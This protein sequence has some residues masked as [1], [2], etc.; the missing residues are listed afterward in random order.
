MQTTP[1]VIYRFNPWPLV[2][3]FVGML[4]L[5]AVYWQLSGPPGL[6]STAFAIYLGGAVTFMALFVAF[7]W[8]FFVVKLLPDGIRSTDGLGRYHTVRWEGIRSVRIFCGFYHVQQGKFG[9]ALMFPVFL[10]RPNEF[11]ADVI[12]RTSEENPLRQFLQKMPSA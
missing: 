1:E 4:S 5:C 10:V 6:A 7:C 12:S 3:F 8:Q 2:G 11:R 9:K